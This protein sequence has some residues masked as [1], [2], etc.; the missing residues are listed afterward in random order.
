MAYVTGDLD[1]FSQSS[2]ESLLTLINEILDFSKIEAGCLALE[3]VN[4]DLRDNAAETLKLLMPGA[5]ETGLTLI[6]EIAASVPQFVRGDPHRLRQSILNLMGNAIKFTPRGSVT[7]RV[8]VDPDSGDCV[9]LYFAVQDT[10]IG[11][12]PDKQRVIFERF[13]QADNSVARKFG[14]TGLGLAISAKLAEMMGGQIWV[15]SEVGQGS[16]FHF[17]V[18]LETGR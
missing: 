7:L 16:T 3:L 13:S 1:C 5:K 11:I 2:L 10:G 8:Q 14:G 4:F 12:P 6:P 17:T 18:R 15:E 9:K